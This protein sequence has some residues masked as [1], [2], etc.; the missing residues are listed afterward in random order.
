MTAEPTSNPVSVRSGYCALTGR[1]NVGKSTLLNRLVGARIS[2]TAD[3]PQTTRQNIRGIVTGQN[4]QIVFVDTPGVHLKNTH[5]L[6]TAMNRGAAAAL[7]DVDAVVMVV[8][9]GRWGHEED[10]IIEMLSAAGKPCLLCVNKIDRL[11]DRQALLPMLA[12]MRDRFDFAA[13]VP[14]SAV[15]GD[16]LDALKTEI[17]K[18]LP[19]TDDYIYPRDQLSDRDE[20]FIVSELIREQLMRNLE[21]ELPYSVYVEISEYEEREALTSIAATIWVARESHKAIVIGRAGHGLKKIGTR[22]RVA[23]ERSLNRRC[24]LR[25]WVKVKPGWQDDARIVGALTS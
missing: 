5:L 9:A 12:T 7:D 6:N 21:A 11:R 8:E 22:A 19:D 14:V 17:V 10:R 2:S 23:I 3:R 24:Y 15:K 1:S 13:L 4:A 16:N 20:R 25:L 18:L